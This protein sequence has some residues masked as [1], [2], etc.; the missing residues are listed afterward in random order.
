MSLLSNRLENFLLSI[1]NRTRSS[2]V[3]N[4]FFHFSSPVWYITKSLKT[5]NELNLVAVNSGQYSNIWNI[6][7]SC[8]LHNL[9][10]GFS[11]FC[12]NLCMFV[13]NRQVPVRILAPY[14]RLPN[15]CDRIFSSDPYW[16]YLSQGNVVISKEFKC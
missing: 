6:S 3:E 12:L 9:Q 13:C 14:Y 5:L 2:F 4:E 7:S 10:V 16:M 1:I 8:C 11:L 15:V